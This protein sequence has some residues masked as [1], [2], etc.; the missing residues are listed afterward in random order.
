MPQ[1]S[2]KHL[3]ERDTELR[4][5]LLPVRFGVLCSTH[6]V[7]GLSHDEFEDSRAQIRERGDM[8]RERER[9]AILIR[10]L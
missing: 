6:C 9:E 2:I 10:R 1:A 5:P 4:P 3:D 8:Q 7:V